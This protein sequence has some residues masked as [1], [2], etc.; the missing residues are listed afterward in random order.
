MERKGVLSLVEMVHSD[1]W[2]VYIVY[3]LVIMDEIIKFSQLWVEHH[4]DKWN[5]EQERKGKGISKVF[6]S[7]QDQLSVVWA[8]E[9]EKVESSIGT[10]QC[11]YKA[12]LQ[13]RVERNMK[14]KTWKTKHMALILALTFHVHGQKDTEYRRNKTY[15]QNPC[16]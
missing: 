13:L 10:K 3:R 14:L 16:H 2:Q 11:N 7:Q 1:Y 4:N 5:I 12:N 6:Y 9:H 8:I 15:I